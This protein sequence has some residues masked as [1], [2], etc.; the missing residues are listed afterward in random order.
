[1]S[2]DEMTNEEIDEIPYRAISIGDGLIDVVAKAGED[3]WDATLR[4]AGKALGGRVMSTRCDDR[5]SIRD[6]Y[7]TE[8]RVG[9]AYLE[10]N[11]E[12]YR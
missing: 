11:F 3:N 1:M 4:T 7:V 10:A 2:D 9:R 5:N 8:Y 12:A 6:I